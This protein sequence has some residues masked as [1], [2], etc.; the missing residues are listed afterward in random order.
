MAVRGDFAH[1]EDFLNAARLI[2]RPLNANWQVEGGLEADMRWQG[3]VHEKFPE[4][5]RR[6]F[7]ARH[8]VETSA[9]ESIR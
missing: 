7:S 3:I 4:A 5:D 1:F 8:D 6:S 9:A 2:G